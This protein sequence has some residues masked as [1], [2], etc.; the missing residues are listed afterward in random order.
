MLLRLVVQCLA[1]KKETWGSPTSGAAV[2][3]G[4]VYIAKGSTLKPGGRWPA[5][6]QQRPS[7]L[8]RPPARPSGLPRPASTATASGQMLSTGALA[9][10][11]TV[12][13]WPFGRAGSRISLSRHT[14]RRNRRYLSRFR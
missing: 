12:S 13:T 11:Q 10:L 7:K 6:F 14:D 8:R 3:L 2:Q 1:D 5:P 4:E 9:Q